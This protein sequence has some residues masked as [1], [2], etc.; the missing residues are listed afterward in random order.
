ME[1]LAVFLIASGIVF[2]GMRLERADWTSP[3]VYDGDAL[4][5]LP[6]VKETVERGTHWT[7]P[8]LGAPETQ[9]LYDFPVVDNLHFGLIRLLGLWI[10]NPIVVFNLFHVLTYPL[11]ALMAFLV[12][13]GSTFSFSFAAAFCGS[14]LFAFLPYHSGRGFGH[15]FLSAYFCIPPTALLCQWLAIGR[16]RFGK[17]K[18]ETDS[19]VESRRF[20]WPFAVVISILTSIAGAYYAFFGCALLAVAGLFGAFSLRSLRPLLPTGVV[21]AIV[22]AVGVMQHLP[23]YFYHAQW[24]KN[25]EPVLRS[26]EEADDYPLKLAQLVLP[27]AGH[28]SRGMSN[29]QKA[30]DAPFRP[31]Q[32]ENRSTALGLVGTVGLVSLLIIALFPI[33][34]ARAWRPMATLVLACLLIG[35]LGGVG[36][37]CAFFGV[38]QVRAYNRIAIYLAFFC[39]AVV[40][41]LMDQFY[42]R[43]F[44]AWR[45]PV[46]LLLTLFGL[47]DQ[48]GNMWFRSKVISHRADIA[49]RYWIDH[50]FYGE[51]E[52]THAKKMVFCLPYIAYPETFKCGGL[53]GY[54]HVRGYLHT[55][56]VRWSFGAMKGREGDQWQRDVCMLPTAEMLDRLVMNDFECLFFDLRGYEPEKGKAK[57]AELRQ[58]LGSALNPRVHPDGQQFL[59]DLRPYR[60]RRKKELGGEYERRAQQDRD[61]VRF[62][63]LDGFVS[64]QLPGE[65]WKH[66]WCRK[67][68]QLIIVNPSQETKTVTVKLLFKTNEGSPSSLQIH[69]EFWNDTH[70][71]TKDWL[72]I[73]RTFVIPPG[74]H[75]VMFRCDLPADATPTDSRGNAF[76][77]G[78]FQIS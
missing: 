45:I 12:L 16:L 17:R 74:R 15:Y 28:N 9:Q 77:I 47:W 56:R 57:L 44:S 69:G 55:S 34:R 30:Y 19:P 35:C 59:F 14:I 70:V 7:T 13:R 78:Q 50:D 72:P 24:G 51:L 53:S 6:M 23:T 42:N 37:L 46:F 31:L 68:G 1:S 62:L 60:E 52:N 76:M 22:V 54:D 2:A 4:L 66:H 40:C 73:E 71:L 39:V 41:G 63:W 8:R 29:I 33:E 38:P 5:I 61:A 18:L 20:D 26:A 21:L 49:E 64:Y 58:L 43:Y 27:M 65:E 75:T 36:S 25:S 67:R 32:N 3:F 10:G 11:A 48:T